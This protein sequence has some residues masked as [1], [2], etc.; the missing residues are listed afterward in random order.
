MSKKAKGLS[1]S[2][3]EQAWREAVRAFWNERC[4]FC[5]ETRSLECHHIIRCKH[6]VTRWYW[7]NGVPVCSI[8]NHH[9]Y[10]HTKAGETRIRE[11]IG[12]A[13]WVELCQL[14]QQ[15]IKDYLVKCGITDSEFRKKMLKELRDKKKEVEFV[16]Y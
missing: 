3:L 14:E 6:Y 2:T 13:T 10:A 1:D 16:P 8:N 11:I 7:R 4:V 9:K 5:G 12:E 15:F